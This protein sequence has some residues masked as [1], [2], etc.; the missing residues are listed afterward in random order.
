[1]NY[2][3]CHTFVNINIYLKYLLMFEVEYSFLYFDYYL[4]S[5]AINFHYFNKIKM[6]VSPLL[7]LSYSL[8]ST[9]IIKLLRYKNAICVNWSFMHYILQYGFSKFGMQIN[10]VITNL[11][12]LLVYIYLLLIL[13]IE[14]VYFSQEKLVYTFLS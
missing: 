8:I 9:K 3:S 1:M 4:F 11:N 7:T 2:Y 14:Y 10:N 5:Y 12:S 6:H 13:C